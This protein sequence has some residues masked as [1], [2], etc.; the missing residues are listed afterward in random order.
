MARSAQMM[1]ACVGVLVLMASLVRAA[2]PAAAADKR[3][4][5]VGATVSGWAR[6]RLHQIST[7]GH[8]RGLCAARRSDRGL[9]QWSGRQGNRRQDDPRHADAGRQHRQDVRGG[10][11]HWL[12]QDG[13][14]LLDDKAEKWLGEE[15]W[16]ADLPNGHEMTI[17]NLLM[18]RSGVADHVYDPAFVAAVHRDGRKRSTP[19]RTITSSR[20]TWLVIF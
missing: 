9:C 15:P 11:D 18:H 14:L 5:A 20:S 6:R 1:L 19:I 17:R 16:F 2:E 8:D 4:C 12:A 13:K 7:A 3:S 10:H